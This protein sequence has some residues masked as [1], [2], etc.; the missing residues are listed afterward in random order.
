MKKIQ[1]MMLMLL[2]AVMGMCVQSC[3][4]DDDNT[5]SGGYEKIGYVRENFNNTL[6]FQG[7]NFSEYSKQETVAQLPE[8]DQTVLLNF[9]TSVKDADASLQ[10]F[11]DGGVTAADSR[12]LSTYKKHLENFISGKGFEG[13]IKITKV[14]NGVTSD[15]G[16]VTFTK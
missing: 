3:G 12:V 10:E 16:T 15:V 1:S 6:K 7:K 11:V 8:S 13:Y 9:I 14:K 5:P 4:S 2:V